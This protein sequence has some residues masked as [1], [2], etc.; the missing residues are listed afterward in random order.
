MDAGWLIVLFLVSPIL[1]TIAA[2]VCIVIS[3][4]I[5]YYQIKDKP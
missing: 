2:L 5:D 1:A 3:A 4:A